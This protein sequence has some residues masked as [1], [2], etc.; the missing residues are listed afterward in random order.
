[1]QSGS[2][3]TQFV[4]RPLITQPV[5]ESSLV[6][7]RGNLHPLARP[8]FDRGPAPVSLG[9]QRQLLVLKRTTQQERMLQQYLASLEDRNSPNFHRFLTP[10]QFGQQY[11]PA[12]EDIAQVVSWLNSQ[13][14]T[15]NKVAKSNMAIEFSGSVNQVE[16]AFHTQIDRFVI[17]GQEHV[18]NVSNP[19]IPSALAPVIAGVSPLNDFYPRPQ[20]RPGPRGQWDA[21]ER[22]FVPQLTVSISSTPYLF[23]SPGDA[24]TIYD[25]PSSLN[26]H[27]KAGQAAYDGTGVTIGIATDGSV[28]LANVRNY[29]ALF[30]L[31]PAAISVVMDGNSPGSGNDTESTLDGEVAGA[32]APGASIVYYQ[33]ADTT[34]QSGVMLAILRA[35]DDNSVNILNVSYSSCELAQGAA[36]NQEVL[37]AWEQAAAQG[38]AVTVSSGDSGSAGCDNPDTETVASQGFGVN[39]LA[40]TPYTVAVGGTDF[41]ALL[42]QFATYVSSTNSANYTSALGYIPETAWNN[43]TQS[44]GSVAANQPS[45]DYS[46]NTNIAA[47]SGGASSAGLY[48]AAG[49]V[50][51]GYAKP[52]W[53]QQYEASA[54]IAADAVR[55]IPDVSLFAANGLYGALWATCADTDCSG[56]SPTITGIGG[57]SA[58]APAFAGVLALVNQKIGA[59]KRLG[60]PNWVLYQLAKT[61]PEAFHSIGTG[62]NSVICTAGTPDC[63]ANGFLSGY[64]AAGSYNLSNGLGSVDISSLVNDWTSVGK[65]QTTTSLTL[66]STT[67]QHGEP[68]AIGIGVNPSAA[69]GNVA[70]TND[71]SARGLSGSDSQLNLAL[72][73]G[74]ATG[75][76]VAFPGGTYNVYANYGG[77]ANYGGS[78][79]TPTQITVTPEDSILALTVTSGGASSKQTNLAGNAVSYGTYVSVDAQPIGKSQASNPNPLR[80][81]TGTVTFSDAT[82]QGA[83]GS[84]M[85]DASGNAEFPLHYFGVGTHTVTAS[86]WGDSSYNPSTSASVTFTVQKAA[87]TTSVTTNVNSIDSG[88]VIVTA[89]IRPTGNSFAQPP[90]GTITLTDTTSGAVLGTA[91]NLTTVQDPSTGAFYSTAAINVQVAQ[92]TLGSNSIVATYSGDTNFMASAASAPVVVTCTAGCGNGTGQT[93]SLSFAAGTSAVA[94]SSAG[95]TTTTQV[96]IGGQGGF[97]GAVNLTCSVTGAH[98]GDVNIPKCSF[99]PA[100]ITIANADSVQ[101]TLTVTTTA[102]APTAAAASQ[103]IAWSMVRGGA[104]MACMLFLGFP[105]RRRSLAMLCLLLCAFGLGGM[106]AC[107]GSAGNGNAPS[108]GA[109][110]A[111]GTT[112]D[113]YTITFRAVDAATGTLTAQNSLT[114][115]VN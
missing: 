6:A 71:L 29:R 92:L 88:A 31:P 47:G 35:I 58:S 34:F 54:G 101:S 86:Y 69:T 60:Q 19:M 40:S 55:D 107:G 45:E 50:L 94:T 27:L 59:G 90:S 79:S 74:Q 2:A 115:S 37:N 33:A 1:M 108:A 106:V 82:V 103:T 43:S 64:D 66:S 72:A 110:A 100:T 99:S 93:L 68:I 81:A 63:A 111:T 15:V 77:D 97:T 13:G 78:V 20:V 56:A 16:T 10:E 52:E 11:G 96:S 5:N 85:L 53:Q 41:D 39:A 83:Q 112:P 91:G 113:T 75:S 73:N 62:N 26:T 109:S 65:T 51:G 3:Q 61:H 30:Q 80:N 21:T 32:I 48:D 87:T 24:A 57:T 36:G 44:N 17:N 9:A 89:A 7:L 76:W 18:A 4:A 25:A 8:Q 49:N 46:G 42:N 70:I 22:R 67:F 95:G 98:S 28:N 12:P 105:G 23:V 104:M 38:I 84:G 114:I 102:P 14:F